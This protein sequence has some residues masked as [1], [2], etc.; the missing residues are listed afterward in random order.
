[1]FENIEEAKVQI[2]TR[3]SKIIGG[4]VTENMFLHEYR[5]LFPDRAYSKGWWGGIE[6][7]KDRLLTFFVVKD[8]LNDL[9]YRVIERLQRHGH[10]WKQLTCENNCWFVKDFSSSLKIEEYVRARGLEQN[11]DPNMIHPQVTDDPCLDECIEEYERVEMLQEIASSIYI[12][13][14]FLNVYFTISNIDL[15]CENSQGVPIYVEIKFKNE[16]SKEYSNG[17]SRLVFGID[18]FQ[19]DNL[20]KSF[21]NSGMQ[22][23]NA[24]LY[25]DV[26]VKQNTSRTIIFEFL[27]KKN[28]QG[29]IWKSTLISLSAGYEKHSVDYDHT[30]WNGKGGRTVYCIPLQNYLE[31]GTNSFEEDLKQCYPESTWGICDKCSEAKVIRINRSNGN[32]FMGCLGYSK[33]L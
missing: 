10:Y 28:N 29:L 1:M 3:T 4:Y 21:I 5:T 9:D 23:L 24:V 14:H 8:E 17:K 12:E 16:F 33:H 2:R 7:S 22:V 30:S 26:K 18:E 13:D 27:R 11:H 31:F 25:N 19:Y 6:K 20:F 15:I 32:E